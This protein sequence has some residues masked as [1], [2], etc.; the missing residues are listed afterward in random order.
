MIPY[1]QDWARFQ[2]NIRRVWI[3]GSR[4]RGLQSEGS[5][6]NVA[7]EVDP[8]VGD[9][10]QTLLRESALPKWSLQIQEVSPYPV[11]MELYGTANVADDVARCSM[12]I[13]E[14]SISV[15]S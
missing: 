9:Q 6:L 1:I 11:H 15:V 14:R 12:L 10:E 7:L 2:P 5:D 4:L 13:Y 3:Y 8:L